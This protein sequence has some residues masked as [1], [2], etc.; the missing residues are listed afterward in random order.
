MEKR[1]RKA[2]SGKSGTTVIEL[3][4]KLGWLPLRNGASAM[5]FF[6]VQLLPIDVITPETRVP[7]LHACR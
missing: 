7:K 2:T 3:N 1:V 4:K 5:H 6:V